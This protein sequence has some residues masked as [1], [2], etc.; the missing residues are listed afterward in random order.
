[1]PQGYEGITY[2]KIHQLFEGYSGRN[3]ARYLAYA[4][5]DYQLHAYRH[6][7]FCRRG[8]IAWLVRLPFEYWSFETI[9]TL[10][11][12]LDF[13]RGKTYVKTRTTRRA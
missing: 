2:V 11:Y 3:E 5:A 13:T 8:G 1:M 4:Q 9:S 10:I 7:H 6:C 12:P